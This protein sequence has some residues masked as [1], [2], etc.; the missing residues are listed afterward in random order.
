MQVPVLESQVLLRGI[1]FLSPG[2]CGHPFLLQSY[3]Q[4]SGL[5]LYQ[6]AW[7]LYAKSMSFFTYDQ[8]SPSRAT[9]PDFMSLIYFTLR[10]PVWVDT[11]GTQEQSQNQR[12]NTKSNIFVVSPARGS[13]EQHPGRGTQVVMQALWSSV[14]VKGFLNLLFS[15]VFQGFT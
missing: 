2:L 4:I 7:S 6:N 1:A 8:T 10:N 14:H 13:P 12:L 5:C 9:L 3:T 15:L 11:G